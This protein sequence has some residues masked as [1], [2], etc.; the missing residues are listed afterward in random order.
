MNLLAGEP[1]PIRVASLRLA[2]RHGASPLHVNRVSVQYGGVCALDDVSLDLKPGTVAGLIGPNGA[3]KSTMINVI[4]GITKPRTGNVIF[5][6]EDVSTWRVFERARAGL[7]RTFQNLALFLTMTV[8][9]NITC[10]AIA[11]MASASS[12]DVSDAVNRV[13]KLLELDDVQDAL[14]ANLS[15]ATRKR[16][17]F[18]RAVVNSPAL[19]LLDEPAAG[20]AGDEI[21]K[22][23]QVVRQFATGGSSVLLVEHDM[24]LVMS[25]CTHLFVLD[26]GKLIAEGSPAEVQR[27]PAV[28]AAYF[29]GD[30]HAT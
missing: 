21:V 16:V 19:I 4:T 15:L 28:Q 29:G 22:F 8:R 26:F 1:S 13:V 7:A 18:A 10:G 17:E 27:N 5:A 14:V 12:R 25:L 23:S 24:N 9:E 11:V 2:S 3:G 6:G 20:L 30:R